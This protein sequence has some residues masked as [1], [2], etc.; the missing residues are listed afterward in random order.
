[1]TA[2]LILNSTY[3][4]VTDILGCLAW[5]TLQNRRI[6]AHLTVFYKIIYGFVAIPLPLYFVHPA[7]YTCHMHSLSYRQIHTPTRYYQYLFFP[8]SVVWNKLPAISTMCLILA[9]L[10][11]ESVKSSIYTFEQIHVLHI[12]F[13]QKGKSR[14]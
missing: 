1:M 4:S 3:N 10:R 2:R 9:H 5:W 12:I 8:M 11:K 6:D 7:V 14:Q 13:F